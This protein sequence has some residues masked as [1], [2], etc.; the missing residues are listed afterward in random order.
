MENQDIRASKARQQSPFLT[1]RE[2]AH[3]LGLS[4]RTLEKMRI[5]ATGPRFRKHSRYV[6]YHIDDL[7]MWSEGRWHLSTSDKWT[8]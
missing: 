3:Y 2:S 5:T 8:K 7:D 6:R 1:T 4:R